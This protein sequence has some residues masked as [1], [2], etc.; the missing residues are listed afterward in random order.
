M[1][2]IAIDD[3]GVC[4]R[5]YLSVC[6]TASVTSRSCCAKTAEL[7]DVLFGSRLLNGDPQNSVLNGIPHLSTAAGGDY[8]YYYYYF[9]QLF[10]KIG[11]S[12]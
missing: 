9:G 12:H 2:T 4:G 3:P 5:T 6:V 7:I 10:C 11:V 8:Y 1:H